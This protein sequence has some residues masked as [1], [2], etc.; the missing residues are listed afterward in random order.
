VPGPEQRRL[1][2]ESLANHVGRLYRA[3][4]ALCGSAADAEDLVQDT[5]ERVL[6]RPRFLGN[7]DNDLAYLLRV[8]RNTWISSVRAR[9]PRTVALE[10]DEFAAVAN[11]PVDPAVADVVETGAV[12]T[13]LSRL[14]V[15]LREAVAAVD[16]VGLSY[17][18]AAWA[19]G[20]EVGT[21][22]SRLHRAR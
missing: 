5:F 22:M 14:S 6:R 12:Y 4:Y 18:E 21:I 1:E 17:R 8:M 13:A 3:A 10:P 7:R 9:R 16:I 11:T 20:C 15:A 2:P 19:L